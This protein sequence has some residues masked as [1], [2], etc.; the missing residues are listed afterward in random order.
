MI[1]LGMLFGA[2][3]V[4]GVILLLL[5]LV[6]GLVI[7]P[8]KIGFG[9]IKLLIGVLI[10]IPLLILLA[11]VGVPLLAAFIP[12]LVITALAA[13]ILAPVVL[14]LKAIF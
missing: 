12:I 8:F 3:L 6:I 4:I 9:L 14:I 1:E 7:L 2:V 5:K 11:I 10:G 13:L